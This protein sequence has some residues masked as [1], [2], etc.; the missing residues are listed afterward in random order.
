[1]NGARIHIT[2][3]VQ[4]VG[5]RPFVYNLADE[6]GL[7]GWVRNSSAGV[8]IQVDGDEPTL[9]AFA[10]SLKENAPSLALIAS[11]EVDPCP[12]QWILVF[13]DRP[14][15]THPW[16]FSTNLTRRRHL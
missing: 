2:G 6:L 7:T 5:F 9:K 13:R 16:R 3:I 12:P 10:L 8:D 1:M 4:G 14:L 11:V 15:R